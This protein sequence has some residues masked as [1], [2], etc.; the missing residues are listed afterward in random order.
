MNSRLRELY[1]PAL[2][3]LARVTNG[4]DG[5]SRPLL[6]EVPETYQRATCKLMIVGQQTRYWGEQCETVDELM[7]FYTG[8]QLGR[9]QR[10]SQFWQAAH[11]LH[12]ALNPAGPGEA[13]LWSNLV[14][15]DQLGGRLRAPGLEAAVARVGLLQ[16]EIEITNPDV[17]VF[18]TGP[19][20]DGCLMD[21]FPGVT[22]N[23]R[24]SDLY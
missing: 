9:T 3:S 24:S 18:F 22:F 8:F 6:L 7:S 15:V 17:V 2:D 20:Y 14:K 4:V 5:I 11:K 1:G 13:F 19:S 12:N 10:R 16:G 23:E 21:T